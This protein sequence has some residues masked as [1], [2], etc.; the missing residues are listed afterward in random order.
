MAVKALADAEGAQEERQMKALGMMQG[1][2]QF[3]QSRADKAEDRAAKAG[4]KAPAA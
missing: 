1:E 4:E 2:S 3:G